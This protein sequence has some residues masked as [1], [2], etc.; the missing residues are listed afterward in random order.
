M[1]FFRYIFS[2]TNI[3]KHKQFC[4]LGCKFKFNRQNKTKIKELQKKLDTEINKNK[5]F[6]KFVPQKQLNLLEFHIAEHC[7]LNCKS[8]VHFSPLAQEEFLDFNIFKKDI[9]RMF[10]LTQGNIK[11]IHI[12]GGEPLLN[13]DVLEY[14]VFAREYF[15]DSTIKLVT[16]GILLLQQNENF[17]KTL[18][19][20][21]IKISMTQYPIKIDY[22]KIFR[23]GKE[24]NIQIEFFSANKEKSQWHF[25]LDLS[26]KQNSIE[27]FSKCQEANN[28]TNIYNGK[29]YICPIASNI[30][31]FNTFFDKKIPIT[32]KDYIDIYKVTDV[33]EI[34][35]FI[36]K[37]SPICKYCNIN[38]RTFNNAWSISKK[39]ISEWIL[40]E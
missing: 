25:P 34:L 2:I 3:D 6:A 4:I 30:R 36:S 13:K 10:E 18:F 35:T 1:N 38:G 31:H 28:C 23:K 40:Y 33:N 27:N 7:N 11:Y 29:I 17:W 12:F 5:E 37:P 19:E 39:E 15:K 14:L 22:K 24:N 9:I 16:N 8:C 32:E 26:G 20:N 21:S